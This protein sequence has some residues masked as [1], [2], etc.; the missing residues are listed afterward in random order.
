V[1][2]REDEEERQSNNKLAQREDKRVAQQEDGKRQ[3]NN[4]LAQQ[5][6]KR[7]AH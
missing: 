7:V 4:Q 3:F 1:A 6:N 5:D 2:Q